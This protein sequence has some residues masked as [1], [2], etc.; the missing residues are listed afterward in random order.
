M[1]NPCTSNISTGS[2]LSRSP[3]NGHALPTALATH[4]ARHG[5]LAIASWSQA[6]HGAADGLDPPLHRN[7]LQEIDVVQHVTDTM[8]H[9]EEG[10]LR[11]GNRE[12]CLFPQQHI[13]A[14]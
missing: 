5:C 7:F 1:R 10:L 2:T 3:V 6:A 11:H 8:H 14:G 12:P 4:P 9:T 13:E